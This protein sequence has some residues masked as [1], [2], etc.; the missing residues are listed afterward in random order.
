MSDCRVETELVGA[1]CT[2]TV[3]MTVDSAVRF[4]PGDTI[5]IERTG[6]NE[7][8]PTVLGV[9]G[10][11]ITARVTIAHPDRS[12]MMRQTRSKHMVQKLRD[13]INAPR[14]TIPGRYG[15][16]QTAIIEVPAVASTLVL[17]FKTA[18]LPAPRYGKLG[19]LDRV[20]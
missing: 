11:V 8:Q 9:T 7:E 19:N 20:A 13:V 6:T 18:P 4:E 5:W 3:A 1:I 17:R 16:D 14:E 2:G 15:P 10:S 12:S